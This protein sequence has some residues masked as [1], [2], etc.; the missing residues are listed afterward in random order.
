MAVRGSVAPTPAIRR[1]RL[2]AAVAVMVAATG[3]ALAVRSCVGGLC[4][5]GQAG[6]AAVP[7]GLSLVG[8][9]GRVP[10]TAGAC[11]AY[12]PSGR[13]NS[14][15]VFIDAGH[16]GADPGAV[17]A[18]PGGLV[19][20]SRLTL[21][22][23]TRTRDRLRAGGFRVV[24]SRSADTTVARLGPAAM[25]G[26]SLTAAGLKRDIEARNACANASGADIL[27]GVHL[28]SYGDPAVSGA[29]TLYNPNR[30]F[31]AKNRVLAR[32]LQ[33][34]VV[35]SLNAAG[36]A[37]PDRGVTPD[38]GAGAEA[39]TKEAAAYDQLL[40]LGPARP[41]WFSTPTRMPGAIVEPLF[42]TSPAHARRAA[43]PGGQDLVAR[44]LARGVARYAE[45]I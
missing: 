17:S 41:P 15:T 32:A 42:L 14:R 28:N 11:V 34:S 4:R 16:G 29:E 7:S 6:A 33:A 44:A 12:A 45:S 27:L 26:N 1:R 36:W 37:T 31:S 43:T 9:G 5:S 21:A 18:T 35:S 2:V 10:F 19:R 24:Q 3:L 38:T 30:S 20:E 22:I 25:N 39:L 13:A 23:A 8:R 40:Q